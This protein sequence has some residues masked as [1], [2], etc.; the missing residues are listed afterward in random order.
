MKRLLP[1][2]ALCLLSLTPLAALAGQPCGELPLDQME[3]A[4]ATQLGEKVQDAL[5][6]S[7]ASLAFVAR[8]GIDLSDVGLHYSH[9]GVAWRDHPNGRWMTFHLL[10]NC[11]TPYSELHEQALSN[12][13]QVKLFDYDALIA[14]PSL[15]AQTRLI[16]AFFSPLARK[17]HQPRYN[18]IAHPFSTQF[19]NSNQWLLEVSATAFAPPNAILNRD[20]AQ[21]WLKANGYEPSRVRIGGGRRLGAAM[22]SPHVHFDD[23]TE[24]EARNNLYLAVTSDSIIRFFTQIDP[25]MVTTELSLKP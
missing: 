10:N 25:G 18:L 1:W 3:T 4:K 11:G 19:Q 23:H 22:F 7:G 24:E 17:L 2:L 14:I 15:E 16:R 5:E 12:F 8:V 21:A 13:Y 6:R 20:Q 9:V